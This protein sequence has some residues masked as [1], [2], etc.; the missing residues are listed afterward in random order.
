MGSGSSLVGFELIWA[1]MLPNV[2]FDDFSLILTLL[3]A[4]I[5]KLSFKFRS[6]AFIKQDAIFRCL[7]SA[8]TLIEPK[9]DKGQSKRS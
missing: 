4:P 8:L 2:Q 3:G 9:Q 6:Q 1:M 5:Y 7:K